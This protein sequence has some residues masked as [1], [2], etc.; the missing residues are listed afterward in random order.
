[1][2]SPRGDLNN[3]RC[4][5]VLLNFRPTKF[6]VP[7]LFEWKKDSFKT[8]CRTVLHISNPISSTNPLSE[9]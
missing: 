1:M 8:A 6:L 5:D 4:R 2:D 9:A 7:S 3:E